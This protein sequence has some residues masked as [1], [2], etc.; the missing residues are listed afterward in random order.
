MTAKKDEKGGKSSEVSIVYPEQLSTQYTNSAHLVLSETD[1]TMD[2]GIKSLDPGSQSIRVQINSR[3]MMS[4]Q[5]TKVF[6]E[7]LTGLVGAYEKEFGTIVTKPKTK[8]K[9]K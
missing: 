8:K 7:K 2:F 4:L 3:V 6:L 9:K 5:H 1:V